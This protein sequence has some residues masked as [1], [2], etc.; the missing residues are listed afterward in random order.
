MYFSPE[1]LILGNTDNRTIEMATV[2][3]VEDAKELAELILKEL[4]EAG[5]QTLYAPDGTT[6]LKIFRDSHADLIILDWMLPDMN[7]LEVLRRIRGSSGIPVLMLTARKEEIDRVIGLEIGADDYLT[8][9]FGMRELLARIH[10]LLRRTQRISQIMDADR[11]ETGSLSAMGRSLSI[12]KH[13]RP[14]STNNPWI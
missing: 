11:E 3:L 7:G 10:A 8:K 4:R 13:I 5:F 14:S 9:P 6:A 1:S 2:L 12:R